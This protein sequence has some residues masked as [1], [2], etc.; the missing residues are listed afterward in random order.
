MQVVLKA[1]G[2]RCDI[3]EIPEGAHTARQAAEAAGC[4]LDQIVKSLVFRGRQ[5]GRVVLFL[6][7]GGNRVCL[8][9]AGRAVGE[10]LD[11]AEAALVREQTGFAIGGVAPV[12]HLKPIPSRFDPRLLDFPL[13]WAAA[14]TPRHIFAIEPR[15]LMEL[16]GAQLADFTEKPERM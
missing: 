16:S 3:L 11:R 2:L 15:R 13:V 6:T 7:A 1:A 10:A 8:H 12:G 4:A 9:A 14:G 5:S